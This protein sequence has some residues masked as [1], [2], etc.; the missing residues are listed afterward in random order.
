MFW[1]TIKHNVL[2]SAQ[3]TL[4]NASNTPKVSLKDLQKIGYT[5]RYDPTYQTLYISL[6]YDAKKAHT[7]SLA[8]DYIES[9]P[10]FSQSLS[11][12]SG[13]T[14]IL[15]DTERNSSFY[16]FDSI[17]SVKDWFS[18]EHIGSI[19][20]DT[21]NSFIFSEL[22]AVHENPS[23]QTETFI[24]DIQTRQQLQTVSTPKM[25]GFA[26]RKSYEEF[27]LEAPQQD[28]QY[29]IT[30][31]S[32]SKIV[33]R[34]NNFTEGIFNVKPGTYTITDIPVNPG[35]NK[36]E[37]HAISKQHH[38]SH[39]ITHYHDRNIIKKGAFEYSYSAGLPHEMAQKWKVTQHDVVGGIG[40][41]TGLTDDITNESSLSRDTDS[42]TL[43]NSL[44]TAK[45]PG[46]MEVKVE[47]TQYETNPN[48]YSAGMLIQGYSKQHS[49]TL[50]TR[51]D[52]QLVAQNNQAYTLNSEKH[53]RYV[54][55]C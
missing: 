45:K 54:I 5:T 21:P 20:S 18:I 52:I 47:T 10:D 26:H 49:K 50:K 14:N 28:V 6:P 44:L 53:H 7:L 22:R 41:R 51:Q 42:W 13:Y 19:D 4:N 40:I 27:S 12:Y 8:S 33:I 39:N 55:T 46:L 34:N 15:V 32:N 3:S 9:P 43:S 38:V 30:V 2:P 11:N 31:S 24:G 48:N 25:L 23:Q 1:D 29:A 37:I 17:W 36:I 16:S 35:I